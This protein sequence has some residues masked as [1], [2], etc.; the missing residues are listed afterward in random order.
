M[1]QE[2]LM[3]D[4]VLR[5]KVLAAAIAGAVTLAL[6]G[7]A[8]AQAVLGTIRGTAPVAPNESVQITNHGGFDRTVPVGTAGTYSINL[9]VG[10]HTV[11]LL[12]DGKVVTSRTGVSPV[13]GGAAQVNFATTTAGGKPGAVNAT[14]L[15]A[16]N[17]SANQIPPIDV[18]TTSLV[19]TT[20]A[21][22]LDRLPLGRSMAAIALLAPGVSSNLPTANTAGPLGDSLVVFGGASIAENAYFVD[23]M[24]TTE[25]HNG[26]GGIS[27]PYNAMEQQQTFTSGYSAKYG[28]SVGGVINQ[29]G[30]TGSNQWHFGVRTVLQPSSWTAS[31]RNSYWNNPRYVGPGT[32]PLE[33]WGQLNTKSS[34]NHSQSQIY[35]AYLSGPIVPDKLTFYMEV[36]KDDQAGQRVGS[37]TSKQANLFT[38]HQPKLYAK[39][40]WNINES[41]NLQLTGLE[42]A[43]K[44]WSST[45]HFDNQS[46]VDGSLKARNETSKTNYLLWV[47]NYVSYITDDLTLHAMLGKMRGEYYQQFPGYPGYDPSLPGVSG[48]GNQNPALV[49]PGGIISNQPFS[50]T[51]PAKTIDTTNYRVDLSDVIGN[52]T[53]SVGIDNARVWDEKDG[54]EMMGPGYGWIYEKKDP[55]KYIVGS[56]PGIA[57]W[58]DSP[59]SV[60]NG[61][62]G[63]VVA[64]YILNDVGGERVIQNAQY[65]QDAWQVTPNFLLNLGLRDDAFTNYNQNEQ[66]FINLT[67]PQWAPRLGFAWDVHGDQTLKVF[68]NA[69]RYYLA[70]PA[71]VG[72]LGSPATINTQQYFTYSGVNANGVPTGLTAIPQNNGG[73]PGLGVGSYGV[74]PASETVSSRN[75]EAEYSDNYSLGMEQAF[76]FNG[77]LYVFGANGVYERLGPYVVNQWA[78]NQSF[79]NAAIAQGVAYTGATLDDKIDTCMDLS[80]GGIMI[81][82][83]LTQYIDLTGSDGKLHSVTITPADQGFTGSS[84]HVKRDYYAINLSLEHPF[85]GKWFA[86][87]IYTWSRSWGNTEG[88]VDEAEGES[89]VSLNSDWNYAQVMDGAY[90]VQANNHTNEL[91]AYGYYQINPEWLV[92]GV[93]SV[94]SG[95][96]FICVGSSYGPDETNPDGGPYHWC[97]GKYAPPGSMGNTPWTHD[98]DLGVTYSPAWAQHKLRFN[99][100]VFNV[101]NEQTPVLIDNSY[102]TTVSP[103]AGYLMVASRTA[104]RAA[105]LEV[106]YD[107]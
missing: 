51:D 92:S 8:F 105:R 11:S 94:Q 3:R 100:T 104:P 38:I 107:W 23:G 27:L 41:N 74:V 46:D 29:I 90:G 28:R 89:S 97:G 61:S 77:Q 71:E 73:H 10:T 82:P 101:L 80:P 35:D 6:P 98:V 70:E 72:R 21:K 63:Y 47:A 57:P 66:K 37:V 2:L 76:H 86:K 78:D 58:V 85:D 12:Q 16:V 24:E 48:S 36:E 7:T 43:N 20:T 88:P 25:L 56:N 54:V 31:P 87:V 40:N 75:I 83:T 52:H 50:T 91:K 62:G 30:K 45:Y 99:F 34:F 65:V 59:N 33:Y 19:T 68:G 26:E 4:R 1:N 93:F 44:D 17:V 81:N 79:C 106:S 103:S 42:S 53:I 67:K 14:N 18:T 13:A 102:G 22:Q 96:P 49:S 55:N 84:S 39:I 60:T 69:G 64:K 32:N 5:L 95:T 9:P 15:N